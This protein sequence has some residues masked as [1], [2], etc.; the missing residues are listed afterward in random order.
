MSS[1]Q[2]QQNGGYLENDAISPLSQ[3]VRIPDLFKLHSTVLALPLRPNQL[4]RAH[5]RTTPA[6][7]IQSAPNGIRHVSVN[8]M[9]YSSLR[10]KFKK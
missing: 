5:T 7:L 6:A 4:L 2:D 1:V 3:G 10:Q 8:S 9:T